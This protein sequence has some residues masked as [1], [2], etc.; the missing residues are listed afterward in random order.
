M[1]H[2]MS[3][4]LRC[5]GRLARNGSRISYDMFKSLLGASIFLFPTPQMSPK[6]PIPKSRK[7]KGK[8]TVHSQIPW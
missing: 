5:V 8:S 1:L 7:H 6:T 2:P 4:G 3:R